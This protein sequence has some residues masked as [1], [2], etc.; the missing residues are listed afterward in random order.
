MPAPMPPHEYRNALKYF[1]ISA[2]EA[3]ALLGRTRACGHLWS[4]QGAPY[5][6]AL[7]FELMFQHNLT[8]HDIERTGARWRSDDPEKSLAT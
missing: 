5:Y 3:A 6:V 8:P 4:K 7:L 1:N 2:E